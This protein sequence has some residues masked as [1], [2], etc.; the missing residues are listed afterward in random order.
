MRAF[1]IPKSSYYY[2]PLDETTSIRKKQNEIIKPILADIFSV[3]NSSYG[4]KRYSYAVKARNLPFFV[5]FNRIRK[6]MKSMGLHC[7]T[8]K[9][10]RPHSKDKVYDSRKSS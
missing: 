10:F 9:K 2:K 7:N 8:I 3:C 4:V 6:L 5:G 1:S